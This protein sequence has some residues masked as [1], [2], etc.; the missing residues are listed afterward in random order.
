MSKRLMS[1]L[2]CEER[3]VGAGAEAIKGKTVTVHLV[4]RLNKGDVFYSSHAYGKPF[5]FTAGSH[6]FVAGLAKGVL[7]MRVGGKRR[8]RIS[9]HLGYRDQSI[10]ANEIFLIPI[11]PNSV[12]IYEI[13]LLAVGD[14]S[15]SPD[16]NILGSC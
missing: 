5:T 12:L 10:P 15:D 7:G 1:G 6:K 14:E 16:R 3:A 9:P 8:V 4:G 13:E 11:P 2:K